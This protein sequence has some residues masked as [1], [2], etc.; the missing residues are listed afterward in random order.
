MF[1]T[2]VYLCTLCAIHPLHE[3]RDENESDT[4]STSDERDIGGDGKYSHGD[5]CLTHQHWVDAIISAGA[6]A[7]HDTEGSEAAHKLCMNLASTRVRHL[8]VVTTKNFMMDYMRWNLLFS[9]LAVP[10]TFSHVLAFLKHVYLLFKSMSTCVA[11]LN[12]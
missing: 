7:V 9:S 8:D 1:I 3:L 5:M 4:E 12:K 2:S 6:F 10:D 11:V